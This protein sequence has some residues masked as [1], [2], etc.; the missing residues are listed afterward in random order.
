MNL[1]KLFRQDFNIFEYNRVLINTIVTAQNQNF[2]EIV[3]S[4]DVKIFNYQGLH[5]I[6]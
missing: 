2:F 4:L 5:K 6:R 3:L 1:F